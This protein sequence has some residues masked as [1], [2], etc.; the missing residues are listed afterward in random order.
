MK[1]K[2]IIYSVVF[3]LVILAL[4]AGNLL[5]GTIDIP[6]RAVGRILA[7]GT[8]EHASWNFIILESR[9]PQ[10]VTA[11]LC[12]ASLAVSGLM[13]QTAFNNPLA[14]P[15]ILG[16][17]AGASLGVALVM[18]AGGGT[19]IQGAFAMS[20][21]FTVIAGAFVGSMLIMGILLALS[22]VIRSNVM[23]LITGIMIGYVT[24]SAI[25]LLNFFSTAEGVHSYM[26]WGM[27]NFG[28]VS[29]AQLPWFA[30]MCSA[31]LLIAVLLIKPLNALLLGT[32]YAENL[33]VN[34]R[35]TRNL[36]LIATGLLTA[37]TTAFC[38]PIA[39]LGLAVP[40]MARL[41]L[42]TS[43]HNSLM[44]VTLLIGAAVALLCNLLCILP[45][46]GGIIPLNAVT[47]VLGAPVILYVIINQRKI[48]YFN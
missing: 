16:I 20:G 28:G 38:G 27:G 35:R 34:I 7:G 45:A 44:P 8:S 29:R 12:G 23:L 26:I 13:L 30:A 39:F 17:D 1:N 46:T 41:L 10:T 19:L 3:V 32:R 37:V 2:G 48:Q 36:L 9:L 11:L 24:S 40:H 43:N 4:V 31:G 18:L 22:T 33:G 25:S 14:G 5:L 47:P 6:A 42:G 15:S 21:F